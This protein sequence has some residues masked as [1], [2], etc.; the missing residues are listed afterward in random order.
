[1]YR[2]CFS[3]C[4]ETKA[5]WLHSQKKASPVLEC[6]IQKEVVAKTIRQHLSSDTCQTCFNV[7][8]QLSLKNIRKVFQPPSD[9]LNCN[10]TKNQGSR[11]PDKPT[12]LRRAHHSRSFFFCFLSLSHHIP[13]CDN[14]TREHLWHPEH[15]ER[16]ENR[17]SE[18]PLP[19]PLI[20]WHKRSIHKRRLNATHPTSQS[21][22]KREITSL[23]Q[24]CPSSM[25]TL[26]TLCS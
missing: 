21:S 5:T 11:H 26:S 15:K 24:F 10:K 20:S 13:F 7:L 3:L 2:F 14:S 4:S 16:G 19:A 25:A 6:K 18:L 23:D 1:M 17:D 12:Q 22:K 8:K 9:L